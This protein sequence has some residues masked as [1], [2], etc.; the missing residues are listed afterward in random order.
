TP[1]EGKI[2]FNGHVVTHLQMYKRARLGMGYLDQ[3][4]SVFRK[5]TV[6]Q[7]VLAILEAMPLYRSLKRRL[8]RPER[9]KLT[10]EVLGKFGIAHRRKSVAGR[11]SGGERRGLEF[12]RCLVGAP[13]MTLMDEPFTGIDPPTITDIKEIVRDLRN[14]GIGILVTDHQVREI[15]TI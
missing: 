14:Q 1:N 15:L 6:E 5:L 11:P 3:K 4:D 10:D 7:N 13:L 8:T 9:N 12:P 2:V